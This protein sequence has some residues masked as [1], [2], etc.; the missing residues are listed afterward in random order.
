MCNRFVLS[1]PPTLI[2]F[3]FQSPTAT[4]MIKLRESGNAVPFEIVLRFHCRCRSDV[5]SSTPLFLYAHSAVLFG[6]ATPA[7]SVSI[8]ELLR[9]LN[10]ATGRTVDVPLR[11]LR[12]KNFI[13]AGVGRIVKKK[14]RRQGILSEMDSNSFL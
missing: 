9:A 7:Q 2:L 8:Y 5:G 13:D 1:D 14:A 3:G 6:G 11:S 12:R 4:L 10:G